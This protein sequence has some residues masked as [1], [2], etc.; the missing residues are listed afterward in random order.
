MSAR[1]FLTALRLLKAWC[2][3]SNAAPPG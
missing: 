3:H 1:T 2:P